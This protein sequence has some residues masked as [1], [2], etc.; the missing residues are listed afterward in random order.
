MCT[1]VKM[2]SSSNKMLVPSEKG[3]GCKGLTAHQC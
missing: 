3:P 2:N 1:V